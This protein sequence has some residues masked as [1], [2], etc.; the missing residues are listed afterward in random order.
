MTLKE[1]NEEIRN[2]PTPITGCDIHFNCLLEERRKL[3]TLINEN[4]DKDQNLRKK[5]R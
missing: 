5:I 4:E 3:E 1:V 2:Y